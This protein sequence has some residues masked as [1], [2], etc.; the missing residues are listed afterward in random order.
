MYEQYTR[1]RLLV[2]LK[3]NEDGFTGVLRETT[4][5]ATTTKGDQPHE[6]VAFYI[7]HDNASATGNLRN[8][9]FEYGWQVDS[10]YRRSIGEENYNIQATRLQYNDTPS[11]YYRTAFILF[12]YSKTQENLLTGINNSIT[13]YQTN[14]DSKQA[15]RILAQA[16]YDNSFNNT[17][18][19]R[20]CSDPTACNFCVNTDSYN[21]CPFAFC[22]YA[23]K[24]RVCAGECRDPNLCNLKG[25][26][27]ECIRDQINPRDNKCDEEETM[28]CM[29]RRACN[30]NPRATYT[31]Y[32]KCQYPPPFRKCKKP[33]LTDSEIEDTQAYINE[34][35]HRA[36]R[37]HDIWSQALSE[38]VSTLA[39]L[40]MQY[41]E[42]SGC[43]SGLINKCENG[44]TLTTCQNYL[45]NLEPYPDAAT[46]DEI[47]QNITYEE[48]VNL[49]DD[50]SLR[51]W[52]L[53]HVADIA[54]AINSTYLKFLNRF[55]RRRPRR[56]AGELRRV[57]RAPPT[58]LQGGA[59]IERHVPAR[60]IRARYA[61]GR[62]PKSARRPR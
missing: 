56:E 33:Y 10:H 48:G 50:D 2:A 34:I 32:R 3:F 12:E 11:G 13:T 19:G 40:D 61:T 55:G 38:M 30:Y 45:N 7:E 1:D 24:G 21:F 29:D 9:E 43:G 36:N 18:H 20:T 22:R 25:L 35:E 62:Y 42:N 14:K 27:G 37:S 4:N 49:Y 57:L 23:K 6:E 44:P 26:E 51:P 54:P 8:L 5:D 53:M 17:I 16:R 31:G 39:L 46:A 41:V 60:K 47:V 15:A 59:E 58:S 52:F 28:G